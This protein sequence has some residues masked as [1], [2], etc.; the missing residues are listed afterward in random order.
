MGERHG[1]GQ[2]KSKGWD[3]N[4]EKGFVETGRQHTQLTRVVLVG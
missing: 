1:I 3:T 4:M 2:T